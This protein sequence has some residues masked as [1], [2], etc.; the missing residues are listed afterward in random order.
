MV[1]TT[2]LCSVNV[3]SRSCRCYQYAVKTSLDAVFVLN[4]SF[5]I[6]FER[7][8]VFCQFSL[9]RSRWSRTGIDAELDA[10][11][12]AESDTERERSPSAFWAAVL[13]WLN[14]P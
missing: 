13:R 11:L 12:D 9:V 8:V 5:G 4:L 7:C 10:E 6:N 1:C 14:R 2:D 3:S